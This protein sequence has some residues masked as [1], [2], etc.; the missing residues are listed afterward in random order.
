MY[1]KTN[2]GVSGLRPLVAGLTM[3]IAAGANAGE[4]S[5]STGMLDAAGLNINETQF[6]QNLGLTFGGW[7]NGSITYNAHSPGNSFNGPVT[8]G[9]RSN[10]PQMNQFYAYLQKSVATE[11]DAWDLGGRVDFLFGTDA[12]F[13]QAYG[14]TA[15]D[16]SDGRPLERNH[17]DLNLLRSTNRFYDIA[18]PQAYLEAF[19]PVGN[20]LNLKAGHFYTPIGYE[21]VTAPDNFFFTKPYTFQY[22]EPFTH[23]GFMGNYTVNQNWAV[24]AGA[25]TGSA[26]GGWDGGWDR[27]LGS[28]S[29]LFGATWTSDDKNTSANLSGTY[30]PTSEHSTNPWALY[31]LVIKH[32]IAE[33]LH[34]VLQ[35]DHGFANGV[36]TFPDGTPHPED[37]A[38]WYGVN[39]YLLYDVSD[40]LGVG[41]RAEWFRDDSGFRVGSPGRCTAGIN[42]NENFACGFAPT[43]AAADYYAVTFGVNWKPLKWV[44]VR[45]NIRY[46]K[47]DGDT[48]AYKPFDDN[49]RTGQFLLSTDVVISF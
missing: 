23:T 49:T 41:I 27:Q 38:Q 3:A 9:D 10:E 21:V 11:G 44:T 34:A 17:W 20:G 36:I 12:I 19:I 7:I 4:L 13:T 35:H 47:A 2:I 45:P 31:S 15:F 29:A 1:R 30:G 39:A 5:E 43:I 28:W 18:L 46:D 42:D 24:M 25:V 16:V 32:N 14:V 8:F 33:H 6:M 26:T 48:A 37:D 22:G 40:N